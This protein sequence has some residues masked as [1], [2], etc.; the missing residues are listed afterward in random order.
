MDSI[1][2]LFSTSAK[3]GASA[4]VELAASVCLVVGPRATAFASCILT[5]AK[6]ILVC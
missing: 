4:K 1:T 2:V 6:L 3:I 5:V